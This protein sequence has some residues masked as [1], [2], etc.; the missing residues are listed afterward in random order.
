ML[1]LHQITTLQDSYFNELSCSLC[2][3]YIK[4]QL[5]PLDV[6]QSS[7]CS[8]CF[9][10]IKSQ[11]E[12]LDVHQSSGCSLCFFYIKSQR[13]VQI[14]GKG[15]VVPYA[16]ST[17]NH[18]VNSALIIVYCVVPYASSTS[19]HNPIEERFLDI[20]LFLML[21]LHQITTC[22]LLRNYPCGCSLCFFYIKSQPRMRT[23]LIISELYQ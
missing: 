9:F 3:F 11:L 1:L 7:G 13:L 21:L 2:F 10:Y 23:A 17:S 5:E 22:G 18:N 8:L 4:S 14:G 16:S 15:R 6:H 12:P 20:R 19:N